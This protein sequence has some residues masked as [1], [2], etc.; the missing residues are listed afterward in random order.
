MLSVTGTSRPEQE[1]ADTLAEREQA[2]D[3]LGSRFSGAEI[4]NIAVENVT[5]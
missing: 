3:L 2:A 5:D 4:T 1:D